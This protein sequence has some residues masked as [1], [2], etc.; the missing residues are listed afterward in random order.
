MVNL[1]IICN[2]DFP[3][4]TEIFENRMNILNNWNTY[5]YQLINYDIIYDIGNINN[6]IKSNNINIILWF[7]INKPIYLYNIIKKLYVNI[8]CILY[9]TYGNICTR[10][11]SECKILDLIITSSK[12]NVYKF[13]TNH[14]KENDDII[15]FPIAYPEHYIE[16]KTSQQKLDNIFTISFL[17]E[18][19]YLNYKNQL[20]ERKDVIDTLIQISKIKDWKFNL[21]GQEYLKNIYPEIYQGNPDYKSLSTIFN[22]SHV[23]IITHQNKDMYISPDNNMIHIMQCRGLILSDNVNGLDNFFNTNGQAILFYNNISTLKTQII[24]IEQMYKNSHQ[25]IENIKNKCQIFSKKYSWDKIVNIIYHKYISDIEKR[26]KQIFLHIDLWCKN[27]SRE[28]D[29]IILCAKNKA[30]DKADDKANDKANHISK[31]KNVNEE[32]N[33]TVI[34]LTNIFNKIK[35]SSIAKKM[36]GINQIKDICKNNPNI[37]INLELDKYFNTISHH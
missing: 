20:I 19:L 28:L 27:K 1:L 37:N 18:S 35:S 2:S 33:N 23:N 34:T 12:H 6:I 30:D 25:A 11:I 5:V 22:T 21:Y 36:D 16:Y 17:C 4:Y 8:Y 3:K 31:D 32:K 24:K 15:F 10:Y 14:K 7:D 13:L 29:E 9:N 26:N